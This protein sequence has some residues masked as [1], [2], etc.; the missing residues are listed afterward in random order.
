MDIG[1]IMK[2]TPKKS[3]TKTKPKPKPAPRRRPHWSAL[4][5]VLIL[6]V[7]AGYF[8]LRPEAD[9]APTQA[10]PALQFPDSRQAVYLPAEFDPQDDLL[11]GGE[12]LATLH[13]KVMANIVRAAA[14]DI[15]IR[16]LAGS[17]AGHDLVVS[18]LESNGLDAGKVD[19]LEIP[20]LTMWV[21]DFGPLTV[22]DGAGYRSLVDFHFRERRG[23]DLDDGVPGHLA[24]LMGFEL[25]TSPL[26][27][28]GGDLLTNGRGLCLLSTRII[29][30]NAQYL[31]MEPE[32]TVK[33]LGKILGFE[34]V[35]LV[36]PLVGES[37]GH[38]DMFCA[39]LETDL[40]V[41]GSY[42]PAVDPDNAAQ[43]DQVAEDLAGLSTRSGLARVERVP[44]P[45]H[46]DGFWRTYTNI[47]F[48]N[49]V[50][51]V[52]VY[53][54]Y[55][56][57]LDETALALFRKLLPDRRVIGIDASELIKMN[58]ALRCITMNVPT[59]ILQPADR[60]ATP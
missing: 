20:V 9:P 28:E 10:P 54:D 1:P 55:C 58:G 5:A 31:T 27:V 8:L 2:K 44:M 47:I 43:L 23:N 56:P 13:P 18:V 60:T 34:S 7:S 4:A 36:P 11:L 14:D 29:N 26:L 41:V 39:F 52:P 51:M 50:V 32:D 40:I 24:P 45:D 22:S 19:I 21:R 59:G 48:A 42:D 38:L 6:L 57:D 53:P 17:P 15:R 33:D 12:Q 35:F 30:R 37:T 46:D 25:Q 49:E 16:I 3:K